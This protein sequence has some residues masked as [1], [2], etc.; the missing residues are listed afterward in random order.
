M[1]T[2]AHLS[3][4]HL[5]PLPAPRWSELIG[6][7]V[8]GYINWHKKRRYIHDAATLATIVADIK[9]QTLDHVAVTGDI[10][11][12]GLAAEFPRGRDWLEG[13]GSAQDVTLV[14]G[15]HDIYVREAAVLAARQWGAYMSDDEG[16]G[17]FPFVRRRNNVALIGLSTG[18]PTAPFLA[19]GWLGAKQLAELAATLNKLR[20]EN[21]FRV[22]LIHHPPATE[23]AQHKRLLDAHVLKRVIAAHGADLLL[24][25]HDH[26]YM[27]NWLDGPNGTRVPA[28]GV[29]SASAA[30]DSGKDSAAYNL[31]RIDGTRGAWRCELI[32]R[33]V[34]SSGEVAQQ[35]RVMLI[36]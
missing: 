23:A 31:Y 4:P 12:I 10:A 1:F 27:L 22:V 18:V 5:A 13:L 25:G 29:P 15:N 9:T 7:R 3:D 33:G 35:K 21:V 32:S 8:T 36:G 30:P 2:L 16:I 26:L 11:N 19:T 6:K 28:M 14:P 24:H 20:T 17:G 34:A